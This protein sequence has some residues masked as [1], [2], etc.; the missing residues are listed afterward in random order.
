LARLHPKTAFL[1]F[2]HDVDLL[3]DSLPATI[4]LKAPLL[5]FALSLDILPKAAWVAAG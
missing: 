4:W 5:A 3:A 2:G 1:V